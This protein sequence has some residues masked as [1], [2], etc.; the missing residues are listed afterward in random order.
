MGLTEEGRQILKLYA[1]GA[2]VGR[3]F[4][5]PPGVPAER[6]AELRRA[7]D[8]TMADPALLEEVKKANNDLAPLSG[9]AMQAMVEDI[10]RSP[11]ALVDRMKE[12]LASR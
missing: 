6:V 12:I 5:A 4:I 11:P 10:L 9:E 7:F 1:S 3:S 2:D 8:R